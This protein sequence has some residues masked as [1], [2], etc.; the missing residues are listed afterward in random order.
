VLADLALPIA[1]LLS[2]QPAP[3]VVKKLLAARA[4]A[5]S[6]GCK[7]TQPFMALSFLSL[8]VIGDL[9]LT[10]GGLVDVAEFKHVDL[11]V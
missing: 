2:D 9:K 10:D 1:G 6:L 7:L 5:R 8:S 11:F 3:A 4:A